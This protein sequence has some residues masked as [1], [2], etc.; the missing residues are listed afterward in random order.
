MADPASLLP[1][2]LTSEKLLDHGTGQATAR[3]ATIFTLYR[4][5]LLK[6][7]EKLGSITFEKILLHSAWT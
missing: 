2:G 4:N 7:I 3:T 6:N 5:E 1:L